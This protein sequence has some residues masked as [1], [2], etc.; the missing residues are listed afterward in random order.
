MS[1][2]YPSRPGSRHRITLPAIALGA[3]AGYYLAS[4]VGFQ[5]RLPPATTSV[6][7]PPNAVLTSALLLTSPRRWMA[8]LL[9]VLPVHLFIQLQTDFPLPMILALFVTNCCEALLAAGGMYWLSDAPTRFDTLRRLRVFFLAAVVCAPLLSSFADAA[10][11]TWLRGE[12]YWHVWQT[13]SLS[14]ILAEVTVV[15]AVVG[16]VLGMLRW[17]RGGAGGRYVEGAVLGVGVFAIG[18]LDF[19]SLLWE[20]PAI[21]AVSRQTPLAVQLPFLLWAATRF[22]PTGTGLTLLTTS[23]L[24]AFAAVHGVGPFAE[25]APTTTV[26]AL[27]ISLIVVAVTLLSLATLIEE[28]RQAQHAL[29]IRLRFEELL[30]RLS[31]ALVRLPSDQMTAAFEAWLG[32]IGRVLGIDALTVFEASHGASVLQA[33]YS[34]T[35]AHAGGPPAAGPTE[36]VTWARRSLKS[37]EPVVVSDTDDSTSDGPE[38]PPTSQSVVFKAGGAIPLVG[39]GELIGALAFGSIR[40]PQWSDDLVANAQLVGE[41]LASALRRKQSENALRESEVMKSAILQSL[42]TGVAVIDCSGILLQVNEG[43]AHVARG[44]DWMNAQVGSNLLARCWS[45][46]ESGDRM[47]GDVVAGVTA[48]LEGSR[49]R[50]SVEH[51]T[52][53]KGAAE[54]WSLSAMPLNRPEGGAVLTRADITELRRAEME[55]ERSRQELAHVSRVSTVGEMTASLAHQLNQ[56]LAA[57]MTNAQ[58]GTRILDSARPDIDEIRAILIDIVKDDRRASDVIQRLRELLRKG[59]LEM[60]KVNLTSAIRDVVDLVSSEAIIRNIAVS[61]EFDDEAVFVRGDRVQLQQV[62][63]NLLHNAMEAMSTSVDGVRRIVINC[64][65]GDGQQVLVT[66]RDSGP[67][68]RPG[69]EEAIFEPFYTTKSSGM[70]MGLS[71]VRSIL[72]AHGGAIHAANDPVRGA[73]FEFLIPVGA[74]R[75]S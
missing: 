61:L 22:G 72:E 74:G 57:I 70:G 16:G 52:D 2:E 54:W 31:A 60:T 26:T 44:S 47:A 5:L 45:A 66:V 36:H 56:P 33:V 53:T 69:T 1:P 49:A 21:G 3:C 67:G 7:W 12:P 64:R 8:I 38:A 55:A 11:V 17:W 24:T 23:V 65:Q 71:I 35:D 29:G 75:P 42:T 15:P 51:R 25:I 39:E 62:I 37:G 63:L 32:R 14:N 28:R 41:V 50:F 19:S 48:V 10:A 9:A 40:E 58:A 20:I 18:L 4:L 59:Q 34:W 27:T 6:L 43:W 46:F 68:V 30:S 13:R 73:V